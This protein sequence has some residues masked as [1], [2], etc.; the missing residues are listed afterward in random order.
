[1]GLR[2]PCAIPAMGRRNRNRSIG[3]VV[4]SVDENGLDEFD[5]L[6]FKLLGDGVCRVDLWT[7]VSRKM[8]RLKMQ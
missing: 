5:Y 8:A 1:M 6:G 7:K 3:N 2:Q 4:P